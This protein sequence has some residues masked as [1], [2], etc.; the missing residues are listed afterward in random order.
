MLLLT[1]TGLLS[2]WVPREC[3]TWRR[4]ASVVRNA[5]LSALHEQRWLGGSIITQQK[6]IRMGLTRGGSKPKRT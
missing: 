6:N 1:E 2:S 3:L 4:A 5:S